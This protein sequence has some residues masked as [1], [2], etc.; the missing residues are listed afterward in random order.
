[1]SHLWRGR[2]AT[3]HLENVRT[4]GRFRPVRAVLV[5]PI[6]FYQLARGGRLATC[7]FVPTCS[8]YAIEA[9]EGHG[10]LAGSW[11]AI[12]R[13]ARCHPWG[14]HGLDP[15]PTAGSRSGRGR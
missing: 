8:E 10:A 7:R 15:V 2:V 6:R 1:M 13:L 11:L 3:D 14:G 4:T 9:I 12:R 5:A